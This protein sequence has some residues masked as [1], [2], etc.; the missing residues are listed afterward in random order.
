MGRGL[1]PFSGSFDLRTYLSGL[2]DYNAS[3]QSTLRL[4]KSELY[5][6]PTVFDFT[7]PKRVMLSFSFFAHEIVTNA[8]KCYDMLMLG[9]A[10]N[11]CHVL[12]CECKQHCDDEF[13]KL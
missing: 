1:P 2:G 5:C 9:E 13:Q 3:S 10:I 11:N 6:I 4:Y 12:F 8:A 7:S